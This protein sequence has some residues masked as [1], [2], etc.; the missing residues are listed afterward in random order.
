MKSKLVKSLGAILTV[1]CLMILV[2]DSTAQYCSGCGDYQ[3]INGVQV[4][5]CGTNGNTNCL[6]KCQQK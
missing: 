3:N 1:C 4:F 6:Y 5:V 2:N